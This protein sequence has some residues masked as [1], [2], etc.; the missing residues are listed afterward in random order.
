[1][2][3]CREDDNRVRRGER[4]LKQEAT[5]AIVSEKAISAN[6]LMGALHVKQW[7][8]SPRPPRKTINRGEEQRK[9][10]NVYF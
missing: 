9:T 7:L 5:S 6:V 3:T 4:L 2:K 8:K 10:I 1:M